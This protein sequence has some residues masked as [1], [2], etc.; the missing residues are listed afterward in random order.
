[1]GRVIGPFTVEDGTPAEE[2]R[3]EL[4][5]SRIPAAIA[6][7]DQA[8]RQ[9]VYFHSRP[10]GAPSWA[11][12]YQPTRGRVWINPGM[13]PDK[14][15]YT[16][17]HEYFHGWE[18]RNANAAMRSA[19]KGLAGSNVGWDG[20][21]YTQAGSNRPAEF[22]A[23]AFAR[24]LGFGGGLL[25]GFYDTN[26]PPSAYSQ[27]FATMAGGGASAS[28]P[29]L[30]PRTP[31]RV[32]LPRHRSASLHAWPNSQGPTIRRVASGGRIQIAHGRTGGF[33]TAPD[34]DSSA[35]WF[36]AV[37]VNGRSIEPALWVSAIEVRRP[38]EAQHRSR[39]RR[40]HG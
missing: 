6:S 31:A 34:G 28:D 16:I 32:R 40:T 15:L 29:F 33:M 21:Y 17:A 5:A 23:D 3:V 20:G 9:K 25:P 38:E 4:V 27:L 36:R 30:Q 24:A 7:K 19:I 10:A 1:M 2:A 13:D 26:I 39:E 12:G 37:A 22:A 8:G 11:W 14:Q 18:S 35:W